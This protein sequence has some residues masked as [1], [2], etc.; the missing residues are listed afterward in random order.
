[1][2]HDPLHIWLLGGPPEGS[3]QLF[4]ALQKT[5]ADQILVAYSHNNPVLSNQWGTPNLVLVWGQQQF[6]DNDQAMAHSQLRSRLQAADVAY[7]VIYP[8]SADGGTS[9]L[10]H[11]LRA[12]RSAIK[13]PTQTPARTAQATA[14][15]WLA[16]C[17]K[18]SDPVCEHRLF[19]GLLQRG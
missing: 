10:H 14:P 2:A 12:V 8:H 15:R 5:F 11:A 18:C 16:G 1:M 3:K 19:T 9:H 4:T 7:Q 17:E 6:D 13:P